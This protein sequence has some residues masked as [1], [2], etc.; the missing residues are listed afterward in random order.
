MSAAP[1]H[2][3]AAGAE[4]R[5]TDE[6]RVPATATR[7]LSAT[8][9]VLFRVRALVRRRL[10][11]L[12]QL[13]NTEPE[14]TQPTDAFAALEDRDDPEAERRWA[15]S[16]PRMATLASVLESLDRALAGDTS[17]P[18][19][20]VVSVLGLSAPERDVL[21][22][23]LALELDPSLASSYALALPA[24]GRG[25]VT[26]A[27]VA[28]LCGWSREERVA[29]AAALWRWHVVKAFE[30]G[31]AEP[32]PLRLEPHVA[33]FIC[34]RYALDPEIVGHAVNLTTREPLASWPV[35]E[36]VARLRRGLD[37]GTSLR[38]VIKGPRG[39]GRRTFAATIAKAFGCGLIAV[40]TSGVS[41]AEWP[42]L[43]L[44]AE[45]QALLF[46]LL[47]VWHGDGLGRRAPA[48][49]GVPPLEFV[50]GESDLSLAPS[51]DFVDETL[52]LPRPSIDERA[53]LVRR[54]VPPSHAWSDAELARLAER[55]QVEIGD[56]EGIGRR[57]ASTLD[58]VRALCREATRDRLGELGEL[59]D[60]PFRREDLVLSP[61]LSERVDEFLFE[62]KDRARF[63][64]QAAARRLFPR[65]TGLVALMSGP[66]GTGKTMAAQVIA[67][68]LGLD[69]FRIDLATS[70]SKYIGET[71][72][73]LRR[74]FQ[75]AAEMN[76]VLL[77]DEADAL[78]TKRTEVKD[79]HDRYAN[80]DT[81]YLLQLIE[82]FSGIALLSSNKKQ[83][84]DTA[85][86]RR[87]RYVFDFPRPNP[88]ER[89]SLWRRI[90]SELAG[91]PAAAPLAPALETL[92]QV[93]D[94]S[95]AQIKLAVL[96]ALFLARQEQ[97]PLGLEHLLRGVARELAKE[98]RGI[99]PA[100]RER[101]LG[102]G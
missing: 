60:C 71:A 75:R 24:S 97:K 15:A 96:A 34:G 85:F 4:A 1:D 61:A 74:I 66:P 88:S 92:A 29:P 93:I 17:S 65:G 38:L 46:G 19:G 43:Y 68:E 63:W 91:A 76:A 52:N 59:V 98:G 8:D 6:A 78:F 16:D 80:T 64:E 58:E 62:A 14:P 5:P 47:L 39:S 18:L 89:A 9:A 101:I 30:P 11:W 26:L 12:E 21:H 56:I 72:K 77:F 51:P 102:H 7:E 40:D 84:M 50:A 73:H 2:L 99:S 13:E 55:Y 20:R 44:H 70:I 53:A 28:R 57:G 49:P 95:G 31:P 90:V 48:L 87:I 22:V 25:H 67:S 37:R 36:T 81:N 45:R 27:L 83:N 82:D 3:S 86:V 41:D 54:F 69:L 10:A 35:T 23:C 32:P 100:E 94:A 42:A 79:A 33:D